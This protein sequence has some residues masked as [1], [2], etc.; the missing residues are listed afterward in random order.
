MQKDLRLTFFQKQLFL[1]Y[2]LVHGDIKPSNI[3]IAKD[4]DGNLDFKIIDYGSIT[5]IFSKNTKAGTPS[6][7]SP[8]RFKSESISES[9]E[10][11]SIGVTLYLALTGKY[12]YGE[13]E[14]FQSPSFKEAKKPSKYNSNIPDWLDSVILRSI[15]IDKE[16]RYEHYSEMNFELKRPEKVKPFFPKD[17]TLIERSPLTFYKSGFIIM[18]LINFLLLIWMNS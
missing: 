13:M 5:E 9:S 4:N 11:F 1:K 2:D 7:L 10:L 8:E 12:P 17:A 18:L 15:A 6:F 16:R 3:M 14:P